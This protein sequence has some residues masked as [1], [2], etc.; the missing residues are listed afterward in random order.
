MTRLRFFAALTLAASSLIANAQETVKEVTP[1][2]PAPAPAIPANLE[3]SVVKVFSTLRRP[4]PY[5]PWSKAAPAEVTGSGVVIEG[6]RIL[7][8]AHVVGYASQVEIQAS[9]A[10]DKVSATVVAVA[11]DIDLAI[12]KLD[13]ESFFKTHAPVKRASVLPNVRDQVFA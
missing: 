13:D 5:K 8:N 2:A 1:S 6:N 10:G 7:T 4:D 11:R 3:N 9:Q 12:L